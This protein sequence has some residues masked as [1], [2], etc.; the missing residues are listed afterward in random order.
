M[1]LIYSRKAY[2][3]DEEFADIVEDT[4]S[5]ANNLAHHKDLIQDE[6]PKL[7]VVQLWTYEHS[8]ISIDTFRRC[9]WDSSADAF[10]VTDNW[11]ELEAELARINEGLL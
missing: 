11:D 5:Q 6:Y 8:G 7:K 2:T 1:T 9:Q 3:E 4:A 10:A